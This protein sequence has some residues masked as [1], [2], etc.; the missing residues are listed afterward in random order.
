MTRASG[1]SLAIALLAPGVVSAQ[2]TTQSPDASTVAGQ[3]GISPAEAQR[4]FALQEKIAA[5]EHQLSANPLF[6]GLKVVQNA[7][8]FRVIVKF[9][10]RKPSAS[11]LTSDPELQ[12]LIDTDASQKSRGDF[13]S[14]KNRIAAAAQASKIETMLFSD[15]TTGK[16]EVHV[17]DVEAFGAALAKINISDEDVVLV[18]ANKFPEPEAITVK[19][20]LQ[21]L[22]S[23][24]GRCTIGFGATRGTDKGILTAGHCGLLKR[25]ETVPTSGRTVAFGGGTFTLVAAVWTATTD[26]AFFKHADADPTALVYWGAGDHSMRNMSPYL[27]SNG[28]MMCKMGSVKGYGCH[29]VYDNQAVTTASDGTVYGP[30]STLYCSSCSET[31][32]ISLNGDSGGPVYINQVGYGIHSTGSPQYLWYVPIS[33]AS[34]I[35]T[36]AKIAP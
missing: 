4:R 35:S 26:L 31:N 29:P 16:V 32:E 1:F 9:K 24:G 6:S 23:L 18:Q 15:V 10:G 3:L 34:E 22:P 19:G 21:I 11:E 2:T 17:R 14:L 30:M 7:Q 27:M 28:S 13:I 25:G 8:N 5:L 20:G 12:A 33:R 36:T